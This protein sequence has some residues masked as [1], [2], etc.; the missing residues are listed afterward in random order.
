MEIETRLLELVRLVNSDPKIKFVVS[1]GDLTDSATEKQFY[2]L[3]EILS[4]IKV[5]YLPL[6]GNHDIWPY[7][8]DNSGK[9][10][11]N[12]SEAINFA[13]FK[14]YFIKEFNNAPNFFDDWQEQGNKFGN[15]SFSYNNVKFIVVDN[16]NR[17]KSPFGLPGAIGWSKLHQASWLWLKE[18]LL[19]TKQETVYVL[20]HAPIKTKATRKLL[21]QNSYIKSLCQ[22]AGHVHRIR[23][24]TPTKQRDQN[25][26]SITTNAL[27]IKPILI[28]IKCSNMPKFHFQK[29]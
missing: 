16:V 27:Y 21:I 4:N 11:W 19:K 12:A 6:M 9:I 13:L 25:I 7:S 1:V 17:K 3:Q 18:Q 29:L 15:L 20:S 23:V 14:Q 5:P 22:I 2:R 26:F 24:F 8:R 10:E 28:T